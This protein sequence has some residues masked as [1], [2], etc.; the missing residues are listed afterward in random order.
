VPVPDSCFLLAVFA[1]GP[2]PGL[3]FIPYFLG[4]LA[5]A[6]FAFV[7]VLLSPITALLRRLRRGRGAP[8]PET[9]AREPEPKNATQDSDLVGQETARS[10]S[11]PTSESQGEG[12]T[13][14]A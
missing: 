5:W 2:G 8:P 13:H 11:C 6:G 10:E 3:E 14:S 4:L 7:A 12:T 9:P 1:Y